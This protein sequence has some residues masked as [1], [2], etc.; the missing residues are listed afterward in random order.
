MTVSM[1][2][3]RALGDLLAGGRPMVGERA[4]GDHGRTAGPRDHQHRS[5]H[6]T[7]GPSSRAGRGVSAA[8]GTAHAV[9]RR[10]RGQLRSWTHM[11]PLSS[12][13]HI[14]HSV[15]ISSASS[16]RVGGRRS[17]CSHTVPGRAD[18]RGRIRRS[19]CS[20]WQ[21]S[22]R[23]ATFRRIANPP[24]PG[25]HVGLSGN[26]LLPAHRRRPPPRLHSPGQRRSTAG[27]CG[28]RSGRNVQSEDDTH[29]GYFCT[30]QPM[31]NSLS[32]HSKYS[33]IGA[34]RRDLA[35]RDS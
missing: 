22:F 31:R 20:Q 24:I 29:N 34:T 10:A 16:Y 32:T 23:R 35:L 21:L 30:V 11:P 26:H 15:S 5:R 7:S 2:R 28:V 12:S 6:R 17:T 19:A 18:P 1:M 25:V 27:E 4:D 8:H 9:R 3:N 13:V 14:G 33:A